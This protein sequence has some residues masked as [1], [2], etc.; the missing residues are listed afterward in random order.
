MRERT[1]R[2][3][4]GKADSQEDELLNVQGVLKNDS[5]DVTDADVGLEVQRIKGLHDARKADDDK[6]MAAKLIKFDQ[7]YSIFGLVEH[8]PNKF[9]ESL[10]EL[11]ACPEGGKANTDKTIL[12]TMFLYFFEL[13][14][15]SKDEDLQLLVEKALG[16]TKEQEV[17]K[18]FTERKPEELINFDTL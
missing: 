16:W 12:K 1:K 13:M 9:K 4:G 7:V 2:A 11:V 5:S 10:E 6:A 14:G 18:F 17:D 3:K 15:V 8:Y